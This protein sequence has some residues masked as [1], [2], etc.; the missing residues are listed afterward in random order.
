VVPH[1]N[2]QD[3][4]GALVEQRG[5]SARPSND[6]RVDASVAPQEEEE[7]EEEEVRRPLRR[8]TCCCD[9]DFPYATSVLVAEY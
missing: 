9:W 5:H 2:A 7:E 6:G 1:V 8:A 3:R 4:L